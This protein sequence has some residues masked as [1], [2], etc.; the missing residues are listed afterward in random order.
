MK[1]LSSLIGNIIFVT[2]V[3]FVLLIA[4][5]NMQTRLNKQ[6]AL[7]CPSRGAGKPLEIKDGSFGDERSMREGERLSRGR[8]GNQMVRIPRHYLLTN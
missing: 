7:L 2:V 6:M 8:C 3:G 1:T 5:D 4:A